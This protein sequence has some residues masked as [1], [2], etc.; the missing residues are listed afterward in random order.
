MC[1]ILI[2]GFQYVY[3]AK[4]LICSGGTVLAALK[5]SS[6]DSIRCADFS[7][8][9]RTDDQARAL[10]DMGLRTYLFHGF[11]DIEVITKIASEHDSKFFLSLSLPLSL[12]IPCSLPSSLSTSLSQARLSFSMYFLLLR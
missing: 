11:K 1:E 9:V 4:I 8:L 5:S 12:S 7:V 3:D 2:Q 10:R 6:N